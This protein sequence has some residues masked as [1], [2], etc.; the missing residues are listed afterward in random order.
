MLTKSNLIF[1]VLLFV[2]GA[3]GI[4]GF[5][6]NPADAVARV[7]ELDAFHEVIH[8]MW[9][10]AYPEKD[11]ELLK[12]LLP[13]VEKGIAEV[14]SAKLPGILRGKKTVWEEGVKNLQSA[15]SD[16]AAAMASNDGAK[17]LNA[18][19]MLHTRFAMLMRSISPP[20]KELDDFH[21]V[22]YMLYHHYL[23][24]YDLEKIRSSALELKEKMKA[25]N[26]AE[27][28]EQIKD[29]IPDFQSARAKLSASVDSLER[30]VASDNEQAI[31]EAVELMH[32]NY[33]ALSGAC[34]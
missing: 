12:Q 7:P 29:G 6:Q 25:L 28:P 27:P 19:E 3:A 14:A 23:P 33:E 5:A 16:Y 20:M 31:K 21:S 34:E 1:I 15:G 26:E 11:F 2:L 32:T 22:L 8:K 9:H 24:D 13:D 30:I 18:A 10:D 4:A 17:M